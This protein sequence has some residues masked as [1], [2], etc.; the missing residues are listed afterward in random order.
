MAGI[1][2]SLLRFLMLNVTK[3]PVGGGYSHLSRKAGSVNKKIPRR[4]L[5]ASS[6]SGTKQQPSMCWFFIFVW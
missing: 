4:S 2:L 6:P 5:V 3:R 1:R